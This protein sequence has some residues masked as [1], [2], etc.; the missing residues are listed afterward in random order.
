MRMVSGAMMMRIH[1]FY[2]SVTTLPSSMDKYRPV[3]AMSDSEKSIKR[4]SAVPA[5]NYGLLGL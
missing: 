5:T 4:I 3:T 1:L 2:F